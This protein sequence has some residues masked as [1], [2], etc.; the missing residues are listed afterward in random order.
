MNRVS[1]TTPTNGVWHELSVRTFADGATGH[2]TVTLDGVPVA[3]LD[4]VENIGTDAIGRVTLGDETNADVYSAAYDNLV[5]T[6]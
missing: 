5:V 3:G 6:G 1:T 2:V 4:L